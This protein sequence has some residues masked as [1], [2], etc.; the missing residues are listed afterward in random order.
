MTP[1][2]S[3]NI[4]EL[5][6]KKP[7]APEDIQPLKTA[8]KKYAEDYL[9]TKKGGNSSINLTDIITSDI[10]VA[11]ANNNFIRDIGR[12]L[13]RTRNYTMYE[14]KKDDGSYEIVVVPL[15]R[16]WWEKYNPLQ[17]FGGVVLGAALTFFGNMIINQEKKHTPLQTINIEDSRIQPLYDSIDKL[18]NELN[19]VE[20]TLTKYKHK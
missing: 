19:A 5:I 4:K 7:L 3:K 8:L 10:K 17:T 9:N 14:N 11:D 12:Q 18:R 6:I 2:F 15:D 16:S 13:E 20:D 1:N